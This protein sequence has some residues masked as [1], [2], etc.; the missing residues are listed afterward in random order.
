MIAGPAILGR[1][2]KIT[3]TGEGQRP[4]RI[5]TARPAA[6]VVQRRQD[7]GE[8]NAKDRALVGGPAIK[9]GAIQVAV[10]RLD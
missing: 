4:V 10:A 1:A 6:E 8:G 9:R 5:A 7:T 2:V 3:A